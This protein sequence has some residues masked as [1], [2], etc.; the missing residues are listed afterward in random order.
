MSEARL[1]VSQEDE[2]R[3]SAYG[4]LGNL[5]VRVPT[6]ELL[7]R[8]K[9]IEI[10]DGE[11]NN[12]MAAAWTTLAM[13]AERTTR[14]AVDDEYHALF[15]GI[16]RGELVP[17]ASWYLTGFLMERPLAQLRQDL[18]LLGFERQE[19]V[20]EPEDHAGA[21]MEIMCM[22]I[23]EAGIGEHEQKRFFDRHMEPW[24]GKFFDDLQN[25]R[26]A[27][28]Y[29]AVGVLGAQFMEVE[30]QYLAMLPH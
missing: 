19:D 15:I 30:K 20:K 7:D 29:S 21:L 28:F 6:P 12:S 4:L 24:I 3:A 14:E 17:Y 2:I 5:L 26:N 11:Q 16:G 10:T 13:A 27:N 25:A 1:T 22:M 23:L 8:L 18:K 9:G